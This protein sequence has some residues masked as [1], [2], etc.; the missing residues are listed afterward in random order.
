MAFGLHIVTLTRGSTAEWVD[1]IQVG[2]QWVLVL[3]SQRPA[4]G[5][6]RGKERLCSCLPAGSML[7]VVLGVESSSS[8]ICCR[9]Q[10]CPAAPRMF[11]P[12]GIVPVIQLNCKL[13][14][15]QL[16]Q[17]ELDKAGYYE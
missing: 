7:A 16:S 5:Y 4:G 10:H 11:T 13:K 14:I 3:L 1:L 15:V 9:P 2:Q 17:A 6:L 12:T 8:W